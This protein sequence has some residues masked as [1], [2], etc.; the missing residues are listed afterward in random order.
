MFRRNT[1]PPSLGMNKSED[2]HRHKYIFFCGKSSLDNLVERITA[3]DAPHP[4]QKERLGSK[5]FLT[6]LNSLVIINSMEHSP[7]YDANIRSGSRE[8]VR[9]LWNLKVH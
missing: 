6:Q 5:H 8:I 2:Q 4:I 9:L 7:A 1:L 3:T